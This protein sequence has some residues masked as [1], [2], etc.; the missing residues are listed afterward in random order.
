MRRSWLV[1]ALVFAGCSGGGLNKFAPELLVKV[2]EGPQTTCLDGD[3]SDTADTNLGEVPRYSVRTAKFLLCNPTNLTLSINQIGYL[4]AN[5]TGEVWSPP[6]WTVDEEDTSPKSV[7]ADSDEEPIYLEAKE[8][9]ILSVPFLPDTPGGTAFATVEIQSDAGEN[10]FVR[11]NVQA[12]VLDS[13][14]PDI[15][16][17]YNGILGPTAGECFSLIPGGDIDGCS[18]AGRPFDI[19]GVPIGQTSS[20]RLIIRN[21]ANCAT[22]D[23]P[24]CST[25]LLTLRKGPQGVG[26]GFQ[27]G[28]NPEGRFSF[29][30]ST[31]LPFTLP[32][33]TNCN[34]EAPFVRIPLSFQAPDTESDF[35]TVVVIESND[36]DEPVIEIPIIARARAAPIAIAELKPQNPNNLNEPFSAPDGIFPLGQ[37]YLDGS[38]SFDPRD[39]SNKALITNYLWEVTNYPIGADPGR[40]LINGQG[41]AFPD[42]FLPLAGEYT[43]LLTVTNDLGTPSAA[44]EDAFIDF[45]AVPKDKIHV[46]LSWDNAIN[47]QDLHLTYVDA[48]TDSSDIYDDIICHEQYDVYFKQ[49]TPIWFDSDLA[50][51]GP[52]PRL[53][54]DDRDGIGPENINITEPRAGLYRVY[55]H[56]F[57]SN[58][59]AHTPT[60]ARVRIFLNGVQVLEVARTLITQKQV[61]SA[62]DI[63]WFSDGTGTARAFPSDSPGQQGAVAPLERCDPPG[64]DLPF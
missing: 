26:L 16:V 25:C 11:L 15:E 49:Q 20:A 45:T 64:T 53:D 51:E 7:P 29:G 1:L 32:Q 13:P 37:V 24:L 42:F 34:D 43:A 33:P 63:E 19:G 44:L 48:F 50:G 31:N 10:R 46:Q 55:V 22:G 40:M 36:P 4:E 30:A 58:T 47:D 39:G 27:P 56:Y 17:E 2:Y 61:W 62:A 14:G 28:S 35:G 60:L 54:A 6:V 8:T 21:T 38:L 12:S 57:D 59:G 52:N 9:I 3:L 18:M 5:L 41:T 23:A